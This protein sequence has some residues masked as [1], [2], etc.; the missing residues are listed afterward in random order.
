M[1]NAIRPK[2]ENKP[3]SCRLEEKYR[4]QLEIQAKKLKVKVAVVLRQYAIAG[5]REEAAKDSIF[6]VLEEFRDEIRE[7]RR[8]HALMAEVLLAAAGKLS[9]NE[10]QKWAKRNIRAD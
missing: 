5:L 1:K 7:T 4:Q 3:L 2:S 8:D 9:R 6:E 10:A